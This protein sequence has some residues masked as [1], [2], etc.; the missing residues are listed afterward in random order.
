MNGLPRSESTSE[1]TIR[2][3]DSQC[4]SAIE[5]TTAVRLGR[6][7]ATITMPSSRCGTEATASTARI[8]SRSTQPPTAP[9]SAPRAVPSTDEINAATRPTVIDTRNA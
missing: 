8:S 6:M 9:A 3:E 2:A 5:T 4:V 7:I 1:R